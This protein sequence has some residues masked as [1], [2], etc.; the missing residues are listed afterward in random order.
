MFFTEEKIQ[1]LAFKEENAFC[2]TGVCS[3][4]VSSVCQFTAQETGKFNIWNTI[5]R[6][7]LKKI[8]YLFTFKERGMERKEGGREEEKQQ[9]ARETSIGCLLHALN[10]ARNPGMC[11]DRESNQ[12]PLCRFAGRHAI[13]WARPAG[14]RCVDLKT[15]KA[16]TAG[17]LANTHAFPLLAC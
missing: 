2:F 6:Y 5:W 17:Y 11:P 9:C 10:C 14:A 12:Q 16:G 7:F 8:F 15:I 1:G 13:H 3:V 4:Y